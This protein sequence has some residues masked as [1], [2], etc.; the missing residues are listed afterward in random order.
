MRWAWLPTMLSPSVVG[1]V[2]WR[3]DHGDGPRALRVWH[4]ISGSL[5]LLWC[6]DGRLGYVMLLSESAVVD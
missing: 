4:G 3:S 5:G 6:P 2:L 1:E